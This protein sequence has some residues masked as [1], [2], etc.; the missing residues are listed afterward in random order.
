MAS[1]IS[2]G[3][4]RYARSPPNYL[5]A[6][7]GTARIQH[8][9]SRRVLLNSSGGCSDTQPPRTGATGDLIVENTFCFLNHICRIKRPENC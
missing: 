7:L 8:S 3:I 2:N 4:G 1:A 6:N 9:A 5:V